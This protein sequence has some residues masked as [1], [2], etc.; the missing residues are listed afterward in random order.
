VPGTVVAMDST[1]IHPPAAVAE[2]VPAGPGAAVRFDSKLAVLLRD[3]L[4]TWQ[5]LNATAFLVSGIGRAAPEVIGDPYTDADGTA[6]LPMFRQPVLVFSGSADTLRAAHARALQRR[7]LVAVFTAELFG[8]GHDA[9][10]RALVRAVPRDRL[11]LVGLAVYGP[12]NDVDR[13]VKGAT[14]HH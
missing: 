11:D 14:L 13:T 4:Q 12:R 1:D 3:D 9:A 8:T 10:N 5:R 2:A 6:Y 7:L